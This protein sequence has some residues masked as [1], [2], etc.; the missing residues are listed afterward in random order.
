MNTIVSQNEYNAGVAPSKIREIFEFGIKRKAIVGREN[1][2]DFSI[3]NPTI[4]TPKILNET[5]IK[6]LQSG[7][8]YSIHGYSSTRGDPELRKNI[9][10]NLNQVYGTKFVVDNIFITCGAAPALAGTLKA[11]TVSPD[12]EYIILAPYFPEYMQFTKNSP[13]KVVVVPA[14]VPNFQINFTELEKVISKNTKG[15]IVNSPNNPCGS[16]YTEE[17]IKKLAALLTAKEKE[18]GTHI[19]II[20]DEPYREILF[21]NFKYPFICNYYDNT[22]V[23]YSFSK[24]VSIPGERVGYALVS[25]TAYEGDKVINA[26]AGAERIIGHVCTPTLMQKALAK[27]V[28]IYSDMKEYEDNR[29]ALYKGLKE[30]G[31]EPN[32]PQGSFYM[33]LKCLEESSEKFCLKAR[34]FDILMVPADSFG[35][36]GYARIAFC[37][38]KDMIERSMGAFKKLK[39]SYSK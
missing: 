1:V 27:M 28:G 9:V 23:C 29:N 4:P 11:L 21:D 36:P 12:N 30:L 5:L 8:D 31:Y 19:Y 3:G 14:D 10:E 7:D 20:S 16:V 18:F 39:E 38:K 32:Y 33:F 22:I 13:C 26:I 6:L 37:V 17:T 24:C 2:F 25:P 15:I 35:C 34:E